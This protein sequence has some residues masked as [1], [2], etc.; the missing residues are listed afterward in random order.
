MTSQ[1]P[2]PPQPQPHQGMPPVSPPAGEAGGIP[3]TPPSHLSLGVAASAA[4]Q[5]QQQQRPTRGRGSSGRE[6]RRARIV[7]TVKRTESYKRWLDDNPLQAIIA[8]D[9]EEDPDKTG[10]TVATDD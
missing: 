10:E 6:L 1:S 8:G 5:Q 4:A 3:P 7:I 9:G 2:Q